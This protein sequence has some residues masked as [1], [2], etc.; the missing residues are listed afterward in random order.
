MIQIDVEYSPVP[1]EL[2][3][4]LERAVLGA[5]A[6]EGKTGDVSI[7]VVDDESI[8]RMNR[9]YRNID[10][11]TDVLSFPSCDGEA[12]LGPPDGFLGDI[13]ISLDRAK[14]Q[15]LDYGHSLERELSFLAV[16]GTLHL[17]GYDHMEEEEKR[18]MFEKQDAILERMGIRR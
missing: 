17:L 9:D 10:R 8:H 12:L 5:L 2:P 16:H 15:A 1:A 14:E 18:E 13:A 6:F 3:E 11:P 7:L 4:I